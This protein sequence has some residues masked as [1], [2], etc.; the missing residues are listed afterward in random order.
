MSWRERVRRVLHDMD[1][2]LPRDATIKQRRAA[3]RQC[4][5]E[6]QGASWPEQ[7]WQQERR[8]YLAHHGEKPTD[9]PPGKLLAAME[10]GDIVFPFRGE[11]T[12]ERD[13][14]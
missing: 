11:N 3:L 9:Q 1:A 4:C 8:K 10:S 6:F 7:V 12:D 13:P 5:R 2:G 14:A